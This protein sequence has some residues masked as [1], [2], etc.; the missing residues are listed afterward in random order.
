MHIWGRGVIK[1]CSLGVCAFLEVEEAIK[2][3]LMFVVFLI[4]YISCVFLLSFVV[5]KGLSNV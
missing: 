3:Y 4:I 2:L 5:F 1:L